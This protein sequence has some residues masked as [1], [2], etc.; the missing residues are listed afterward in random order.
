MV[1]LWFLAWPVALICAGIWITLMPLEPCCSCTKSINQTLED[2][3][4]WPLK[5]GN[6]IYNCSS[7]CPSPNRLPRR[8]PQI[9]TIKKLSRD[10]T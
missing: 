10:N 3:V 5:C 6:A 4:K 7:S 9:L 1:I 2:F 8:E